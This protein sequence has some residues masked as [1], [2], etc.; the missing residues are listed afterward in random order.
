MLD[1]WKP[2]YY[3]TIARIYVKRYFRTKTTRTKHFNQI[4][5]TRKETI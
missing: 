5:A 3:Y 2:K 4:P 1:S